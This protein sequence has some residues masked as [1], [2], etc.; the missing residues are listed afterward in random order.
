MISLLSPVGYYN[1]Q[2]LC[3]WVDYNYLP[4]FFHSKITMHYTQASK[5]FIVCLP[6]L[7]KACFCLEWP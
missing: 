5:I 1:L 2:M 7:V 3:D 6:H 4:M